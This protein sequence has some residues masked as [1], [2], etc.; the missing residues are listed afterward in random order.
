MARIRENMC[1]ILKVKNY[2]PFSR[3]I[4]DISVKLNHVMSTMMMEPNVASIR[5]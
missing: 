4:V 2:G 1:P 3:L 5:S